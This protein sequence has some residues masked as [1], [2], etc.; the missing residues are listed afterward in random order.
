MQ[1]EPLVMRSASTATSKFQELLKQLSG[2]FEALSNS[3]QQLAAENAC[4]SARIEAGVKAPGPIDASGEFREFSKL[5]RSG[6]SLQSNGLPHPEVSKDRGESP[7]ASIP[8]F[9]MPQDHEDSNG[10][11]HMQL[12]Q[13]SNSNLSFDQCIQPALPGALLD[14]F[15]GL[16]DTPKRVHVSAHDEKIT[17]DRPSKDSC[18]AWSTSPLPKVDRYGSG[19]SMLSRSSHRLTVREALRSSGF[20]AANDSQWL[21]NPEH[22]SFLSIWEVAVMASLCWVATIAPIQV[23][24][25]RDNSFGWLFVINCLIDM[26]FTIDMVLQFFIMFQKQTSI[27]YTWEHRHI[28]VIQHYLRTWFLIDILSIIPFDLIAFTSNS[29]TEAMSKMKAIK[30]VRLLRLL[31]LARLFRAIRIFHHMELHMSVTYGNMALIRFFTIL[32]FITHWLANLWALCLTLVGEEEGIE[33][34]VDGITARELESGIVD[35]TVDTPWKLY[36]TSLYFTSYTITSVGYGD[37]GP[38]NIVETIVAIFII[39]ASGISW[40]IVLG[41]VCG[42]V[43]ALG[44]EEHQFRALMDSLNSM[45]RDR[46]LPQTMRHR[47]RSFFLSSKRAH[48]RSRQQRI[49]TSMSPGLQG[50]VVLLMNKKWLTKVRIL[51]QILQKAMRGGKWG[52]F[53]LSFIVDVSMKLCTWNFAQLETFGNPHTLYILIRGL[54]SGRGH[55]QKTGS[56]WGDDF[57]L[58]DSNL[59]QPCESLSLTYIE[60]MS[61]TRDDF[62]ALIEQHAQKVPRLQRMVRYHCSWLALQ[63]AILKEAKRRRKTAKLAEA[64][65]THK[66]AD[67]R[68]QWTDSSDMQPSEVTE[69]VSSRSIGAEHRT[70]WAPLQGRFVESILDT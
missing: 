39:L 40:A 67:L 13:R 31:K 21:I 68:P 64:P 52:A 16:D 70:S 59:A 47:M 4:L 60:L 2:E 26:I 9:D 14:E 30:F 29:D 48:R 44:E 61:L 45:M 12:N 54:C 28:K 17:P 53:F 18:D 41:Q 63:R 37:I 43:A 15:A 57:I 65:Y 56:V 5:R 6:C 27:G 55:V 49:I 8:R 3:N 1:N 69:A 23:A 36:I 32:I 24:I 19:G 10:H 34:W 25:L 66:S 22:S 50:E 35:T 51:N 42:V 46:L 58:Q 38:K 20:S 7:L 11:A 33:R 62:M